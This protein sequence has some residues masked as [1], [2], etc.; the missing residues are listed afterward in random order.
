MTGY[1][2]RVEEPEM[3][4]QVQCEKKSCR[5]IIICGS[6]RCKEKYAIPSAFAAYAK[7]MNIL[8]GNEKESL[9]ENIYKR[10]PVQQHR[11]FNMKRVC[12][13]SEVIHY[14]L[15]GTLLIG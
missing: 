14:L 15:G 5:W 4:P 11:L 3:H 13:K 8:L 12:M 6:R 9:K 1:A 10:E 2:V 7:Y